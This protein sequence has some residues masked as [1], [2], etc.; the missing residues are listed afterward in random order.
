MNNCVRKIYRILNVYERN[1][2]G[3]FIDKYGTVNQNIFKYMWDF[4]KSICVLIICKWHRYIKK[5]IYFRYFE[6]PITTRCSLNCAECN[7]LIQ[8]YEQ[9]QNFKAADILRDIKRI[10]SVTEKIVMVRILGGE[11]LVHP[12]LA[13]ILNG[14]TEIDKIQ[15]VQIVTNGT[16]LFNEECISIIRNKKFSVDVSNYGVHSVKYKQ[17]IEQL[18]ENKI[19]YIT[20]SR[21]KPWRSLSSCKCRRRNENELKNIFASCREDCHSLLNGEL[22]LCARSAHG[23]DLG[24]MAKKEKEY[25]NVRAASGKKELQ[26]EIYDLLNRKSI[27]ACN[28]C[29]V[30]RVD[31]MKVVPSAEQIS[32]AD[33]LIRMKSWKE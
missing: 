19:C 12:E 7:N 31:S 25:V 33:A 29:D 27:S 1:I 14:L 10:C 16:L 26:K 6:V 3:C 20:Q 21:R 15:Q 30:Y 18:K 23:T 32:K 13:Y 2:F 9:P 4:F 5:D 24:V 22:H 8:F 17:L 11:P 28:Y